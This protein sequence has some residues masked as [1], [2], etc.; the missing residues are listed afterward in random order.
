MYNADHPVRPVI[1]GCV[2]GNWNSMNCTWEPAYQETGIPTK[3]EL[4]WQIACVFAVCIIMQS[5]FSNDFLS[6][7]FIGDEIRLPY[8]AR[9]L[10]HK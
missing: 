10:M 6:E 7:S 1:T 2:V 9:A 3:Q 8:Q 5:E 4:V